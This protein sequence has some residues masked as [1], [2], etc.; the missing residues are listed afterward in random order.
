[1]KHDFQIT[2]RTMLMLVALCLCLSGLAVGQ[3]VTGSIAGTVKDASGAAVKGATVTISDADKKI[4]VRTLV[5]N[6]D[7]EFSAPLMPVAFYDVT[8]EA[9]SFKK[10]VDTG[11]KGNVNERRSVDVALEAGDMSETMSVT[12]D[13]LQ[14][15]TQSAGASNV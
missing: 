15:N 12:S 14:V 13:L 1:M 2:L 5:T 7:G 8:V 11:V 10:H 9:P 3:E 4:V 6:D